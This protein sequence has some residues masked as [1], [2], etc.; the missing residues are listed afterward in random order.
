ME[1]GKQPPTIK[2][3]S[4]LL[5]AQVFSQMTKEFVL[6]SDLCVETG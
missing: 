2:N 6:V 4:E 3:P 1:V 5:N